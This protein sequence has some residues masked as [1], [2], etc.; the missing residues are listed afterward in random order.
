VQRGQVVVVYGLEEAARVAEDGE[1]VA[2]DVGL[3][4]KP[5]G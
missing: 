4:I 2:G 1:G 3:E 5:A